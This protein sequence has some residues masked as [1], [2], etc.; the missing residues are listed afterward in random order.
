MVT[1]VG[2]KQYG[3]KKQIPG[4]GFVAFKRK[5]WGIVRECRQ[6]EQHVQLPGGSFCPEVRELAL[7]HAA[8]Q[9][10]SL[11]C[12]V[13]LLLKG[14]IPLGIPLRLHMPTWSP[15]IPF[16]FRVQTLGLGFRV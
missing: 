16:G 8:L 15:V 12:Q 3:C 10:L 11:C 6:Y 4:G 13:G 14:T 1:N 5:V 7:L 9:P 2:S